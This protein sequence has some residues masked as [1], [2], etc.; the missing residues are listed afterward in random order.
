MNGQAANLD[1]ST[2]NTP[3]PDCRFFND[4]MEAV[5]NYNGAKVRMWMVAANATLRAY[6][7]GDEC[8]ARIIGSGGGTLRVDFGVGA[9]RLTLDYPFQIEGRVNP[10]FGVSFSFPRGVSRFDVMENTGVTISLLGLLATFAANQPEIPDDFNVTVRNGG[11]NILVMPTRSITEI[12]KEDNDKVTLTLAAMDALSPQTITL[13]RDFGFA[14]A[15]LLTA[16]NRK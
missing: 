1:D 16:G 13:R 8:Y 15:S 10:P 5:T 4:R 7:G 2:P 11:K 3:T 6:S 14:A 12:F 9:R